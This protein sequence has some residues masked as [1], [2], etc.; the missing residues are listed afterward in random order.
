MEDY[1]SCQ[2]WSSS[3]EYQQQEHQE[4]SQYYQQVSFEYDNLKKSKLYRYGPI[5][6]KFSRCVTILIRRIPQ[7][8]K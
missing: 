5:F 1:S 6:L 2:S 3:Q 7:Y 8:F 4:W